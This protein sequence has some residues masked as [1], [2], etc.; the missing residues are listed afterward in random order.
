MSGAA[1]SPTVPVEVPLV[2]PASLRDLVRRAREAGLS[3]RVITRITGLPARTQRRIGSEEFPVEH[4]EPGAAAKPVGRP[5]ALA[6]VVRGVIDGLLGVEPRMKVAELLRRLRSEHGYQEGK[7]PV[8]T[9]VRA[10]RPRVASPLPVVRFEGV[11]GEFA[12]HDFGSLTVTYTDG[13]SARLCF[14]AGRLKYSRALHVSL[15]AGE[16]AECFL[17][18]LEG[19]AKAV[20]G[21]PQRNVVVNMKAAVLS[22]TPDPV[23]GKERIRLNLHF[24]DFLK[25]VGVFAEPGFPYSGSQK[26]QRGEPGQVRQRGL[27]Y[28]A[29]VP[30]PGGSGATTHGVVAARQR[31]ADL[32]RYGRDPAAPAGAGATLAA[33]P[34]VRVPRLRFGALGCGRT[35]RPGPLR[36]LCLFH[37]GPLDRPN[38]APAAASGARG[39]APP[40][41]DVPASPTARER[42]VL[43]AAGTPAAAVCE[44]A[45]EA[46]GAAADPHGSVSRRGALLYRIG[47]PAA[48]DVAGTRLA[49]RLEPL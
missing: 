36:R 5:S 3:A 34:P 29:A 2:H 21:L 28:G 8:Y 4:Q 27:F 15:A 14:Y 49:A 16:T 42:E 39:A 18:G 17:R 9:Y 45:R 10:T 23:T 24:A 30:E 13:K 26:G 22:R 41:G 46:D 32:R 19:F 1:G 48:P 12:Q 47:P 40:G 20:G 25:E 44:A 37:A 43:A 35:G 11:A 31:R 6:P 33:P 7:N 38:G